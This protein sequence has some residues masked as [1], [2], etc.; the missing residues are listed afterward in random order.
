MGIDRLSTRSFWAPG[1]VNLIG[2]YTDLAGGLVL[3]VAL[4]LGIRVE[5]VRR[6]ADVARRRTRFAGTS[7]DAG[8]GR[9]VRAVEEELAA[10]GTP[11]A[12]NRGN[13]PVDAADRRRP[14]VVG[15]A[16]GRGRDGSVRGRRVRAS[17]RSSSRARCSAPSIAPSAFRAGS[18]IRPRRCSAAPA[19][20]FS[21]TPARSSTS[22]SR[23]RRGSRSSS[24]T[25]ASRGSS[26]RPAYGDRRRELEAGHPR[27]RAARRVGERA[28]ARGRRDPARARTAAARRARARSSPKGTQSLRDDF[29]VTIPELDLLVELAVEAGAVAARM[30]GGGF[31]GSIVAL[32]EQRRRRRLRGARALASTGSASATRAPR[33]SASASDGAR[34]LTA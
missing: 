20:R 13:R 25:R 31:G 19:T 26:S 15:G 3:P 14:L 12:R 17:S 11:G 30:T 16:R 23:F 21:S 29:E 8:W 7:D 10:L 5:C 1:R 22:T 27:A 18:W 6:G 28:R 4:D 9:F 34:E 24:S 2:E 32:V 33:T